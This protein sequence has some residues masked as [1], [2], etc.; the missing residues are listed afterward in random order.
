MKSKQKTKTKIIRKTKRAKHYPA[1]YLAIV[2][3]G[4]L[5]LEGVLFSTTTNTDWQKAVTVLDVSKA[6]IQTQQNMSVMFQ[7]MVDVVVTI[8]QFYQVS[9]SEM[10]QLLDLS[11]SHP[12]SEVAFIYN[13]VSDF[14]QQA[15]TQMALLLDQSANSTWPARVAGVSIEK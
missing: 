14:Y 4:V 5:I 10:T 1:H 12:G 7:P 6:V 15:S 3:V 11:G 9:A 2:L 8:N 13:G